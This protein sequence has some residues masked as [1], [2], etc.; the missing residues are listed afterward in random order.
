M[1]WSLNKYIYYT[2]HW[3]FYYFERDNL[4]LLYIKI[5]EVHILGVFF[6]S[7]V[8]RSLY[9]RFIQFV[10]LFCFTVR[11]KGHY[12]NRKSNRR[13]ISVPTH[14]FHIHT[15]ILLTYNIFAYTVLR[16][17]LQASQNITSALYSLSGRQNKNVSQ[18]K[19]I[20]HVTNP[21]SNLDPGCVSTDAKGSIKKNVFI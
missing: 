1:R 11:N 14:F 20:Y 10:L 18:T 16:I 21:D 12:Y 19:L 2:Y 17:V 13:Q 7:L 3:P 4:S 9:L 8:S 15:S 6:M 5:Y